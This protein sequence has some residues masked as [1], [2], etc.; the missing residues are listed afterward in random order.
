MV[1]PLRVS[2]RFTLNVEVIAERNSS[3]TNSDSRPGWLKAWKGKK[4]TSSAAPRPMTL[5]T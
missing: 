5:P 3:R 4:M 2:G 1:D